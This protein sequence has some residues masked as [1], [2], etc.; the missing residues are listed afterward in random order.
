MSYDLT[1]GAVVGSP[2]PSQWGVG[3]PAAA[4]ILD[5]AKNGASVIPSLFLDFVDQHYLRNDD[6]VP[7]FNLLAD[8]ERPSKAWDPN[9][10]FRSGDP[11][12]WLD[13][14]GID[15][16]RVGDYGPLVEGAGTNHIRNPRGEGGTPGT[17]STVGVLPSNWSVSGIPTSAIELVGVTTSRGWNRVRLR[18]NGTPTA[19]IVIG[20]EASDQIVASNGQDWTL[21]GGAA[22]AAGDLTNI[23]GIDLRISERTAAGTSVATDD[24]PAISAD[25]EHRRYVHSHTLAGGGTVAR[26]TGEYVLDWDG[27]GAVDITLDVFVPQLENAAEASSPIIPE[28][29]N[30]AVS[31]RAADVVTGVT[32]SRDSRG[33]YDDQWDFT[34]GGVCGSLTEFLPNVPRVGRKGLLVEEATTNEISNPRAIGA[35]AGTPGTEPTGWAATG[36]GNGISEEIVGSGVENG[37]PYVDLR[38]SGTA[39]GTCFGRFFSGNNASVSADEDWTFSIGLRLSSGSTS[40]FESLEIKFST[41]LGQVGSVDVEPDGFHRRYYTSRVTAAGDNTVRGGFWVTVLSGNAVDATFRIYAPQLEN[42]AYPTS[43]VLPEPGVI[44]AATRTADEIW[45]DLTGILDYERGSPFSYILELSNRT[46]QEE[47]LTLNNSAN[48]NGDRTELENGGSQYRLKEG[49]AT[50]IGASVPAPS[51]NE[52]FRVGVSMENGEQNIVVT[53]AVTGSTT[54]ATVPPINRVYLGYFY[55][56]TGYLNNFITSFRLYKT[57]TPVSK[58]EALVA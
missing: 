49:V 3:R 5:W 12:G 1:A 41:S 19:D 53:G 44:A 17:L 34:N 31:T 28:S 21:S 39:T 29:G 46:G 11:V 7:Q 32:T 22:I 35:V 14:Y 6:Y 24:S 43:V 48:P 26:V 23:D 40:G 9:W 15:E 13:E 52:V 36:F 18:F 8:C 16:Y 30:P 50:L 47:P 57:S 54:H 27:S 20:F 33:W 37:W 51:A 25:A 2:R 42:K 4:P 58:L 10:S 56:G 38:V 45:M 55:N